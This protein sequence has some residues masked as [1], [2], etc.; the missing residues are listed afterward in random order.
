MSRMH[1]TEWSDLIEI[2]HLAVI[3]TEPHRST[4]RE[5]ASHP[6]YIPKP[7]LFTL[8]CWRSCSRRATA[9]TAAG[10]SPTV[11]VPAARPTRDDKAR[12]MRA[13]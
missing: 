3:T 7:F 12:F 4:A 9:L 6:D 8:L 10:K 2:Y 5:D 13:S 1:L 11:D